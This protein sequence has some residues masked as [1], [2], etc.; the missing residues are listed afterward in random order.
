MRRENFTYTFHKSAPDASHMSFDALTSGA[1][2][3]QSRA[4][5][6]RG[7]QSIAIFQTRLEIS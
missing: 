7:E 2:Q 6:D 3:D 1:T 5:L 4:R